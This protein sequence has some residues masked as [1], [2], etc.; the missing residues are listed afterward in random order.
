MREKLVFVNIAWMTFYHG[1]KGDKAEG[2]FGYMKENPDAIVHESWNFAPLKGKVYGYVP[3]SAKINISKIGAQPGDEMATGVTV[4]W[5]AR[6]PRK[7]KTTIVGWYTDATV[8][9]EAEHFS[10]L[11]T[12]YFIVGYQIE[13]P[14]A[15][16]TLLPFDAREFPIPTGRGPGNVGQSPIWYGRDAAFNKDVLAYIRRGGVL[17]KTNGKQPRQTDPELR[18]RVEQAAVNHAIAHFGSNAGGA[19]LVSSVEKDGVGWDLEAVGNDGEILKIEVKGLSGNELLVELTPNEYAKMQS[20]E[21]R[22]DYIVYVLRAAL[23]DAPLASIFRFDATQ[24]KRND[25]VWVDDFGRRLIIEEK[26]AAR[27]SCLI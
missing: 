25:L 22:K 10:K 19:R 3:R 23:S 2:N 17:A 13:A 14:A 4:V 27:L 5:I 8:H 12:S 6:N 18:R 11:R 9:R 7:K 21:H 15:A 16:A 26:L 1:P 20:T 24:S